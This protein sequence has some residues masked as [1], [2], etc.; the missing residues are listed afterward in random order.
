M[1]S[2]VSCSAGKPLSRRAAVDV[3]GDVVVEQLAR[4]EV[5]GHAQRLPVAADHAAPWATASRST[6]RPMSVMTPD[7]SASG[8][9]STGGTRPRSGWFQRTSASKPVVRPSV[10]RTVGW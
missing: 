2:R 6:Q 8:M 10:T 3:G 1:T 7:S 4:G 9:N 5:D